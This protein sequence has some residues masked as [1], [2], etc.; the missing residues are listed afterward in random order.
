LRRRSIE[1]IR[2]E[3]EA[4]CFYGP[5]AVAR[6]VYFRLPEELKKAEDIEKQKK[7]EKEKHRKNQRR[8]K[9]PMPSWSASVSP[10]YLFQVARGAHYY[11]VD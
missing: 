7:V 3:E 8:G 9:S 4:L 6:T 11:L 5:R 1:R 2:E 10:D